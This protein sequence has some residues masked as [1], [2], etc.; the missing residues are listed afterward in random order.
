[1]IFP[2]PTDKLFS[3]GL[4]TG[5]SP[6]VAYPSG[7]FRMFLVAGKINS[8]IALA[9]VLV[10]L[11]Q[12]A[13]IVL[14]FLLIFITSSLHVRTRLCC[15]IK[16][17]IFSLLYSTKTESVRTRLFICRGVF[18]HD[19]GIEAVREPDNWVHPGIQLSVPIRIS[20]GP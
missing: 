5:Q 4:F 18:A 11:A 12:A 15:L 3:R 2:Y 16:D 7:V 10:N 20:S 8:R 14:R 13:R 9:A 19:G 1:M 6:G 17:R